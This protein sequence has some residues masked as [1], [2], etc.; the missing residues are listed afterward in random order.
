ML[1]WFPRFTMLV[2]EIQPHHHI[3][4]LLKDLDPCLCDFEAYSTR[5]ASHVD[6]AGP[7]TS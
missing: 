7:Q 1:S 4:V 2:V 6:V 5:L 3:I